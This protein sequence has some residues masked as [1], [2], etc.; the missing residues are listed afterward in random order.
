MLFFLQNLLL[1][2]LKMDGNKEELIDY[3]EQTEKENKI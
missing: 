2:V 1:K 3:L